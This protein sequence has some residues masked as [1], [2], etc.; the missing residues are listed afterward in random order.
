M[1][2]ST[3][4]LLTLALGCG[5]AG[6]AFGIVS[7]CTGF[8]T[9]EFAKAVED[10]R[11]ELPVEERWVKKSEQLLPDTKRMDFS[12]T[13]EEVRALELNV[14]VV[15]CTVIPCD[16]KTW[17]VEGYDLPSGFQ[18]TQR[19]GT[20][21]LECATTYWGIWPFW[22]MNNK[23]ARLTIRMPQE[24]IVERM[25]LD[26]GVGDFSTQDGILRCEEL[27]IDCGVGDC[28]V[29]A[30]IRKRLE[31]DGGVG[32]V[33]LELVGTEKDFDYDVD[34]GVGDVT[35]GALNVSMFDDERKIDNGADKEIRIDC[36]VGDV[37][38][39]FCEEE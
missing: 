1:K 19:G 6:G 39:R 25:K 5:V 26:V 31:L 27:E 23:S 13:Y 35:I 36:G 33:T 7:L 30:D 16:T 21:T 29:Q 22:G 14:G 24:Q 12:E 10:G 8:R 3:K 4:L 20:L 37:D 34:N 18:C 17:Q 2:K 28:D 11:F 15:D 32:D 9:A 38:V